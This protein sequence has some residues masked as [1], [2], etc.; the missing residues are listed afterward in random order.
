MRKI[1]NRI[2]L[3][4]QFLISMLG[5]IMLLGAMIYLQGKTIIEKEIF[6]RNQKRVIRELK[7]TDSFLK[8]MKDEMLSG[9]R[10]FNDQT[11]LEYTKKTLKLDYLM[12]IEKKD[13]TLR[14]S[15][16]AAKALEK[17]ECKDSD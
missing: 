15:S 7:I 4:N 11:N 13:T 16:I 12:I 14:N 9:L 8:S 17:G 2:S 6:T 3:S 5:I 1:Y 10:F